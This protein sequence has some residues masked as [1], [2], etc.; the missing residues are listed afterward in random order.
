MT[1]PDTRWTHLKAVFDAALDAPPGEREA[2]NTAA[3]LS[4]G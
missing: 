2:L 1:E 3:G 4:D